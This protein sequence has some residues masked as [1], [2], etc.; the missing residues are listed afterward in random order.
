MV[1]FNLKLLAKFGLC[2]NCSPNLNECSLVCAVLAKILLLL[3]CSDSRDIP[4]RQNWA[5][6][7]KMH[8]LWMFL[9]TCI[10]VLLTLNWNWHTKQFFSKGT[11]V[12]LLLV[13]TTQVNSAFRALWLVHSEV[14]SQYYSPPL[15]W[16]IV[17][18]STLGGCQ[19]YIAS[20]G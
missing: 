5:L 3:A 2:S 1:P 11:W 14:I 10:L 4:V 8:A 17:N 6:W 16:I 12:L 13:Y 18:Y 7:G 20:I 9:E 19:S 15:R